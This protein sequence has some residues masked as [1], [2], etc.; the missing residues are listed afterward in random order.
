VVAARM[1]SGSCLLAVALTTLAVQAAAQQSRDDP[2]AKYGPAAT[3]LVDDRDYV[4]RHEAPDF[5]ALT[6]YYLPQPNDSACSVTSVA[7]LLNALRVGEKLTARDELATCDALLA[8]LQDRRWTNAVAEGGPG[9]TLDALGELTAGALAA[10]GLT[11]YRVEVV[12]V[13]D[14]SRRAKEKLLATL[15][16]NERSGGDLVIANFLQSKLTGDPQ[17]AVGHMAPLA[18]YDAAKGRVLVFDPDRRWYEPYWVSADTLL[19][20]MATRDKTADKNRGY[21]WVRRKTST[22]VP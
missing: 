16:E 10:Y 3:R 17:G 1:R 7:M 4:R 18:A 5:W 11:G 2:R 14:P 22:P 9:L 21:L 13:E 12:H 15:A 19:E 8:K 6:P 20:A